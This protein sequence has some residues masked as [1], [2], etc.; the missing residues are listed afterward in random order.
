MVGAGTSAADCQAAC[1]SD[2]FCAAVLRD[3]NDGRCTKQQLPLRYGR[4]GGGYTLS[5]KTGGAAN[6]ASGG[7]GRDT[8]KT[9]PSASGAQPPSRWCASAS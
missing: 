8:H 7:S 3:A 5:V 1:L 4:V 9:N 2:C 6:P